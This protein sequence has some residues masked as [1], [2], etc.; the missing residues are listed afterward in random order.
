MALC[1]ILYYIEKHLV[2]IFRLHASVSSSNNY[3]TL[4]YHVLQTHFYEKEHDAEIETLCIIKFHFNSLAR[5]SPARASPTRTSLA[6][7]SLTRATL[8]RTA[9]W[10][11]GSLASGP[12]GLFS[13][14]QFLVSLSQGIESGQ[15]RAPIQH[16]LSLMLI[17]LLLGGLPCRLEHG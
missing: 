8:A 6:R 16:H 14:F 3:F 17:C 10:R 7:A 9:R 2:S 1:F 12:W 15:K 5:A 4:L 11:I 13:L